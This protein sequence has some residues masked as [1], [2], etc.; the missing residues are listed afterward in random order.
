MCIENEKVNENRH[1]LVCI[2][3]RLLH[4]DIKK[5][6]NNTYLYLFIFVI[7]IHLY[8]YH[9]LISGFDNVDMC[10]DTGNRSSIHSYKKFNK[11]N[12]DY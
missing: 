5:F 8:L 12:I 3:Y 1:L 6:K 10:V 9:K 11:I 2:G 4:H 7:F